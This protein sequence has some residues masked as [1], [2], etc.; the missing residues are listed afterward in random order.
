MTE[1]SLIRR[2][3]LQL[4]VADQGQRL[5]SGLLHPVRL[6]PLAFLAVIIVGA[7]M[8]MLPISRTGDSGDIVTTAFFTAVSSVCVTASSSLTLHFWKPGGSAGTASGIKVT[9]FV[10]PG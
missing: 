8:L 4:A 3:P 9:T 2:S 10:V 6:V 5:V 7:G 1:R